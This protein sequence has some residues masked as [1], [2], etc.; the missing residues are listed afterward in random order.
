MKSAATVI[1]LQ[2]TV[3]VYASLTNFIN[4]GKYTTQNEISNSRY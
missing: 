1:Q 2:K 3:Y 4:I